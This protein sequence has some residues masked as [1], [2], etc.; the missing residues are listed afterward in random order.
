[1]FSYSIGVSSNSILQIRRLQETRS[2]K[3]NKIKNQERIYIL[4][5]I[6]DGEFLRK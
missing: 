6:Y 3:N 4:I 5:N 2:T 1:M